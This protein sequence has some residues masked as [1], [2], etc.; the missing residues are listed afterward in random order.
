MNHTGNA[1]DLQNPMSFAQQTHRI[2]NVQNVEQHDEAHRSIGSPAAIGYEVACFHNDIAHRCLCRTIDRRT[3]HRRI[4]VRCVNGAGDP[5]RR[6]NRECA[7]SAA[8]LDGVAGHNATS[9]RPQDAVWLKE[10]FPQLEG[11]HVTFP[12]F[13]HWFSTG[14]IVTRA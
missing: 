3:D 10:S 2:F 14:N 7:V 9:E 13:S 4:D 11:R 12:N 1:A 5:A 8:E 6:C